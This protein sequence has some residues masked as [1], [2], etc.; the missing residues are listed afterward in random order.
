MWKDFFYFTKGQRA[1]IIILITLIVIVLI[2]NFLLPMF[3]QKPEKK[4]PD[5]IVEVHQFEKSL[6]SRESIRQALW[7]KQYKDRQLAY[8]EKYKNLYKNYTVYTKPE[9]VVL[10]AFDP[11]TLDSSGFVKL[12]LKSF[13][14]SNILKYR[15]RGGRF[16]TSDDFAKVYGISP[17]K[18]KELTPYIKIVIQ[19]TE[20]QSKIP[21][22][23]TD[24]IV[25]LNSAD[26]TLLMQVKGIGRGYARGIVRFRNAAGGF[27][28]V[29]Q[30]ADIYGMRPENLEKIRPY[31]TVNQNYVR[32]IK[33]N[34]ASVEILA[35]HPYI[36][37]YQAKA[38]YELRRRKGKLKSIDDLKTLSVFASNDLPRIKPYLNF[39]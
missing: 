11:N 20:I 4:N 15:S 8:E 37:F 23:R 29:D 2:A 21:V 10:S 33:V 18:M 6:H 36:N 5:F 22:K 38:I 24:I 28:S 14:A 31:C 25:D 26:T 39:E 30:L 13:I 35:S 9:P 17:E 19:P 27:V 3:F 34:S 1:G 7:Q 16:K 32:Q 12:G